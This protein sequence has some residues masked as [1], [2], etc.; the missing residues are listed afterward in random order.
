MKSGTVALEG[1]LREGGEAPRVL[2]FSRDVN[3]FLKTKGDLP[4][5]SLK[6][7][8]PPYGSPMFALFV[9]FL[10][11]RPLHHTYLDVVTPKIKRTH[12]L[13]QTGLQQQLSKQ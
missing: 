6:A 10:K 5:W 1:I 3:T 7:K 8:G 9:W 4:S 11:K 2:R 12:L 13:K